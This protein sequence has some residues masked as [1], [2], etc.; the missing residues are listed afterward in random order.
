[1]FLNL[2]KKMV[3]LPNGETMAYVEKGKGEK[4]IV[5]IHGNFSSCY[6]YEPL[7]K[8]IGEDYRVLAMDLRG[9][10]DSSYNAPIESL[11]DF[12]DDVVLFL[13]E[14]EVKKAVVTGWSLGGC[15][16]MS[17]AARYPSLVEKLILIGSGSVKGYPV[18]KKSE[19]MEPII[20]SVYKTKEELALDPVNV[21]PMLLCQ[22]NQDARLMEN[23]WNM[24][25]Y[26]AASG[27]RPD[28]EANK[29]FI[30]ETLKQRNLVDADW[31]LMN[32][33]ISD[34]ISFYSSG[35]DIAKNIVCPVLAVN[36]RQDIT[37]PEIMTAENREAIKH[38][39]QIYYE[40]CGHSV[41]NDEPRQLL[42]DMLEFIS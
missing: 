5:L 4:V 26:T 41:V 12:A 8:L 1:M 15:V 21:V 29:V 16:A 9:Y 36:G 28:E 24:T 7:Y 30:N 32:Y 22:Q 11:H 3:D 34:Q 31:A 20:G 42:K 39:V 6:H 35:E 2:E 13:K 14:M 17:L 19:T 37:V 38:L 23:I 10:G 33:N 40:D 27:K 18:F 25:I